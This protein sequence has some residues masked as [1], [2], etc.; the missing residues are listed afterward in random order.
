MRQRP[1]RDCDPLLHDLPSCLRA[2]SPTHALSCSAAIDSSW[3]P[4]GAQ[5]SGDFVA[6]ARGF[7]GWFPVPPSRT[8]SASAQAEPPTPK[9]LQIKC[10]IARPWRPRPLL[11]QTW[12]NPSSKTAREVTRMIVALIP[13]RHSS[14]CGFDSAGSQ[15]DLQSIRDIDPGSRCRQQRCQPPC[16]DR[17]RSQ[18]HADRLAGRRF[19]GALTLDQSAVVRR[20]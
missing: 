16:P 8:A 18:N 1:G 5:A 20:I 7:L 13:L 14:M 12:R 17:Y 9:C 2:T 19:T 4:N 15:G 10:Q 11:R 6:L 3:R